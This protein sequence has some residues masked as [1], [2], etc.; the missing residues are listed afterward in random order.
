[1]PRILFL[2]KILKICQW[3]CSIDSGVLGIDWATFSPDGRHVITSSEFNINYTVFS[4]IDK[5]I[6]TI[7]NPKNAQ[8]NL[9]F[10]LDGS[11]AFVGERKQF[12]GKN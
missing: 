11:F 10:S 8:Q 1:M 4:L 5:S 7:E 2:L 12:Q 9:K 3:T 6:K